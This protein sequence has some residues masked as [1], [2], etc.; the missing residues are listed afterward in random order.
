MDKET[1]GL[2]SKILIIVGIVAAVAGI[3]FAVYKFIVPKFIEKY[4]ELDDDD[5]DDYYEVTPEIADEFAE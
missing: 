1:K 3:A 5:E 2:L 4:N